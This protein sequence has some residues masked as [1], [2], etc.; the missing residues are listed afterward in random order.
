[1]KTKPRQKKRKK[2]SVY[3]IPDLA[4]FLNVNYQ[5]VY[6]AV[7]EGR[8]KSEVFREGINTTRVVPL[9]EALKA[10][11]RLEFGYPL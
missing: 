9:N 6:I 2:G 7:Q 4:R 10:A 3:T 1:V 5:R 11:K 8:I